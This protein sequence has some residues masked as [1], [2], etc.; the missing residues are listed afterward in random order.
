[1]IPTK[2]CENVKI[3]LLIRPLNLKFS[4]I[5][6]KKLPNE[7]GIFKMF[8]FEPNFFRKIYYQSF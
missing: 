5:S 2:I 1:M 6:G 8:E 3:E 7:K 4:S